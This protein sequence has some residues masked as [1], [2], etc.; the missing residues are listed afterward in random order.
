M[1][2]L[3]MFNIYVSASSKVSKKL[4]QC[5]LI[6]YNTHSKLPTTACEVLKVHVLVANSP[7]LC[8]V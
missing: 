1:K 3:A 6:I 4:M 5:M 7:V 2:E 8:V